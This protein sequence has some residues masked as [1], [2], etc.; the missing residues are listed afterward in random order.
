MGIFIWLTLIPLFGVIA[1]IYLCFDKT[2]KPTNKAFLF[3]LLPMIEIFLSIVFIFNFLATKTDLN[4]LNVWQLPAIAFLVI[5]GL[6]LTLIVALIE[7]MNYTLKLI[8]RVI[9]LSIFG[10]VIV[11]KIYFKT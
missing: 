2:L 3:L 8:I 5:L 10:F 11:W 9:A 7:D 6:C 1:P 4:I